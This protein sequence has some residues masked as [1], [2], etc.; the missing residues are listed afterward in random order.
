MLQRVYSDKLLVSHTFRNE[1]AGN[2]PFLVSELLDISKQKLRGCL[3]S[4][5]QHAALLAPCAPCLWRKEKA[6]CHAGLGIV[7][8]SW[9]GS[10]KASKSYKCH[11]FNSLTYLK[12]CGWLILILREVPFSV[13]SRF[14]KIKQRNLR[15][16]KRAKRVNCS[17]VKDYAFAGKLY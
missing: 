13:L 6:P 16:Q 3:E 10:S 4:R 17:I 9:H 14:L 8:V 1:R 5:V 2:I 11:N 15:K 12:Q 7:M